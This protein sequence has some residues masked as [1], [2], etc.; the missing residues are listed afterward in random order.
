M[1]P[2]FTP[3]RILLA[4]LSGLLAAQAVTPGWL[5]GL[6]LGLLHLLALVLLLVAL[7]MQSRKRVA[8][9]L[10]FVHGMAWF[11]SG[12]PW[13]YVSLHEH[14]QMH[15]VLAVAGVAL[16]CAYL[17]LF[18]A[19]AA[20][21]IALS[22]ALPRP[23]WPFWVAS[24]WTLAELLRGWLLTGFPWLHGGYAHVDSPL[25]GW[26]PLGG[27]SLV[28]WMA[29]L[30]AALIVQ[31]LPWRGLYPQAPSPRLPQ[32]AGL[33]VALGL[34][35]FAQVLQTI[36]FSEPVGQAMTVRLVQGNVPLS[37]KFDP[38]QIVGQMA[39][40]RELALQGTD[41]PDWVLMPETAI[42]VFPQ[43]LP[44]SEWAAWIDT[45]RQLDRPL[46]LGAPV[47][48]L[49][50]EQVLHTN[51][52]IRIDPDDEAAR[53]RSGE[54]T[55]RYDKVH[56]VPF[57]EFVPTGFRW[58]VDAM[59]M[60][61]GDFDRGTPGTGSFDLMGQRVAFNICYEDI[62]G[63]GLLPAIRAETG[64]TVLANVSNLGWFG[65]TAALPQALQMARMRTLE[66]QRPMVRATNTGATA[67]IDA[68]GRVTH[69]LPF[70]EQGVID[71]TVQGT[72]GLTPYART[73]DWPIWLLCLGLLLAGSFWLHR[74][75]AGLSRNQ[76]P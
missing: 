21:L 68:W 53:L 2:G 38:A 66:T 26:A 28:L 19:A 54:F 43:Q 27:V 71:A 44:E 72:T 6:G 57:G 56:L 9:G 1:S 52:V 69:A 14:G 39:L 15:P 4:L 65:N 11:G 67:A 75:M 7:G 22:R 34:L 63:A 64:A 12:I 31:T 30:V 48:R 20:V 46:V 17:S 60:P 24:A 8:A 45:S 62:F 70:A 23:A 47:R 73:G 18:P 76:R 16:L 51:S 33:C 61:L 50:D 3:L 59:V 41:L 49:H 35:G 55:Q 10:G 25:A 37:M 5:D 74:R 29:M 42:P 40:H 32:L 36:R 13:L 58:F